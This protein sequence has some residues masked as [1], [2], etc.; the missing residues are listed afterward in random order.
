[1]DV[2]LA[3]EGGLMNTVIEFLH[4]DFGICILIV[5]AYWLGRFHGI[6]ETQKAL[7]ADIENGIFI[8]SG[9]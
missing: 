6:R 5:I 4:S 1:V 7:Q 9:K 8:R 3:R 2:S